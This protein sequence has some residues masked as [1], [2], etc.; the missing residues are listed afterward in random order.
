MEEEKAAGNGN[1]QSKPGAPK[2]ELEVAERKERASEPTTR[3]AGGRP[4]REELTPP[5][6]RGMKALL[7]QPTMVAAAE[8]IGVHPRT[9]SR[10]SKEPAFRAE[11]LGQMTELQMELW[12][13]MLAVK[14]EVWNR[15]LELMRSTD[16]RIAL[17]ATTWFLDRMLSVP[18]ILSQ[19][20]GEDDEIDPISL[21]GCGRFLIAPKPSSAAMRTTL[22]E[23]Y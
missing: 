19:I 20:A 21:L 12:R 9:I 18:V 22:H 11:Y 2:T 10:W 14:S 4:P 16:E 13:Q 17:R 3:G 7:T 5:Q 8:E 15:F 23:R 6:L 1:G